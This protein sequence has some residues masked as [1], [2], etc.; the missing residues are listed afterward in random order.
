QEG[1]VVGDFETTEEKADYLSQMKP[2][3]I[4]IDDMGDFMRMLHTKYS[5]DRNVAAFINMCFGKARFHG[6]YFIAAITDDDFAENNLREVFRSFIADK[7]GIHL[8]GIL[9][10]QHVLDLDIG[11]DWSLNSKP[12]PIGT[13]LMKYQGKTIKVMVP[14]E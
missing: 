14:K 4:L 12:M 1:L 7:E 6:V 13:G 11:S 5:N 9:M 3:Y 2:V 8:G 10:E